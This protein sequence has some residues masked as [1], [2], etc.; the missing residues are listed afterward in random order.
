MRRIGHHMTGIAAG[1]LCAP[2][3][4]VGFC[5]ALLGGWAGGVAPDMLEIP[6]G[7]R[8]LIPHR[9]I[10]HWMLLW[11]GALALLWLHPESPSYL[12]YYALLGF[13]A[14]GLMHCLADLP[15][16]TGVPVLHYWNRW[17]LDWW[18]SGRHDISLGTL[19][20]V[21][22]TLANPDT[23]KFLNFVALSL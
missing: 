7:A 8:R 22:A 1:L 21:L 9:R 23:R 10:T 20:L 19:A 17:S 14:G 13:V 3:E 5:L 4:P 12:A 11:A 6:W 2:S 18:A 16:P 15:N